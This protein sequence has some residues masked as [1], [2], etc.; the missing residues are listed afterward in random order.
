MNLDGE[1]FWG[2]KLTTPVVLHQH[3]PS[4]DVLPISGGFPGD[5]LIFNK[6]LQ[7]WIL[8]EAALEE[9][10]LGAAKDNGHS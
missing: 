5:W 6:H 8:T 7:V 4:N 3:S 2:Y 10:K 1:Q 9:V